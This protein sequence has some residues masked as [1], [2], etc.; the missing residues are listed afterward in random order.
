ML[1]PFKALVYRAELI[2]KH[3]RRLDEKPEQ[4]SNGRAA[5][6]T[7]GIPPSLQPELDGGSSGR[8]GG[9]T[10]LAAAESQ[11]GRSEGALEKGPGEAAQ[12]IPEQK[13]DP[14][15]HFACLLEFIDDEIKRRMDY[16]RGG[17]CAR[18]T[19]ADLW[20]LFQPGDV[21]ILKTVS[22][23]AGLV[24]GTA[25]SGHKA[26]RPF[27]GGSLKAREEVDG[28]AIAYVV[29]EFDGS[30][31]GPVNYKMD[32]PRFDGEK[33][34]A[35]LPCHPLAYSSIPDVQ[36][37]LI[38]RGKRFPGMVKVR[39][40]HYSGP[41]YA[42]DEGNPD[43]VDSQVVIDFEE[44]FRH[45]PHWRPDIQNLVGAD[46]SSLM[47]GVA[48][49]SAG[50][51]RCDD[52]CCKNDFIFDDSWVERE[53]STRYINSLMPQH[54]SQ[55]PS[56][57][58]Y[59]RS[60]DEIEASGTGFSDLEYLIMP[61][62]ACGFIMRSRKWGNTDTEAEV[63]KKPMVAERRE[64]AF[65]QLVLP[66]GHKDMVK[67][68]ITQHFRDK[69]SAD[70]ESNDI[71]R[72]KGK[73]LIILLHGAP[74]VGKTSTAECV[75]EY[76]DKPLFQ[77]TCGDLGVFAADVESALEKHFALASRWGCILLL[78]EADVFLSARSPTDQLRN[79]LVSVFLRTLEYYVGCLFLTTNRV[80]DFDEAFASRIHM[81]LYYPPLGLE[82]TQRV[83]NLN[84]GR[85]EK[86][87]ERKQ[88]KLEVDMVAIV[89]FIASYWH[90]YPQARWNGRQIRN[91]CQTALALAEFES[92]K[93]ASPRVTKGSG[94]PPPT[95]VSLEV[96]H[97]Q[98]VADAYLG[99]IEYLKDIYGVHADER[100]KENF[101]RASVRDPA[102]LSKPAS[103]MNPL[104]TRRGQYQHPH[105]SP[106]S[107]PTPATQHLGPQGRYS[108]GGYPTGP[109]SDYAAQG[110]AS[111][112]IN[113]ARGGY[114]SSG[115]SH[116]RSYD[117][118]HQ[119]QESQPYTT[120]SYQRHPE[121]SRQHQP[122]L[123]TPY[124]HYE[125]NVP[126]QDS[127]APYERGWN[128]TPESLDK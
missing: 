116:H 39:H 27:R 71:V 118:Q 13:P 64:N 38:S 85:I 59:P 3:H 29:I 101:L 44:S 21:I 43:Y 93:A 78:D 123:E 95:A 99:F 5:D 24:L 14:K 23:Q 7:D 34:I 94:L 58:I 15:A 103:S 4:D 121:S 16:V 84:L 128:P 11:G 1:Q 87:L 109:P 81:S 114:D 76:F 68:L 105:N 122:G 127:T 111:T 77:I 52:E 9:V 49:T 57:C 91:G 12:E 63:G 53:Q 37:T 96:K 40:M 36:E 2:K 117:R 46:T 89:S 75:A 90:E 32:I 112:P 126:P 107:E 60:L 66:P 83:F 74:G 92:N 104:L 119:E 86:R 51:R 110:H 35:R 47:S 88:T 31:L 45:N 108:S 113:P 100:A 50:A 18:V 6:Q 26:A 61:S 115:Y 125:P 10:V 67:S 124:P 73:G 42:A 98:K 54:R 70:A 102:T 30:Q 20:L 25:D 48:T 65:D 82:S 33:A 56:L 8:N 55:T 19:Y 41:A 69:E 72:G 106:W 17:S 22:Q 80:G 120:L 28:F 97:F 79:S 62:M